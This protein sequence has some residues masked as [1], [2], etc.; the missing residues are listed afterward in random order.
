MSTYRSANKIPGWGAWLKSQLAA[1]GFTQNEF[2]RQVG[3]S[4]STVSRWGEGDQ[5]KG[6]HI[7]AISDVLVLDYDIVATRAGYRP[8]GLME[9][10]PDSAEAQLL[11]Y[12]RAIDWEGHERELDMIKAQLELIAKAQRG[13]L[14]RK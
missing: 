8:R 3:V 12:I 14:D 13:E 5:P 4:S 7:D 9:I 11:P 1:K 10:D 6:S 2:A